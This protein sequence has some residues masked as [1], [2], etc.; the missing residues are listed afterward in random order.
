MSFLSSQYGW[1][2]NNVLDFEVVLA[3]GSIVHATETQHPGERYSS[4][5]IGPLG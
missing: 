5:V 3:D 2:V 4:T 1:G